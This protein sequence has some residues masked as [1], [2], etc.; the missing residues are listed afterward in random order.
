MIY[1]PGH[2]QHFTRRNDNKGLTTEQLRQKY[3][4]EQLLFEQF[5][6][7]TSISTAAG[8]GGGRRSA[9]YI[10]T[11]SDAQAFIAAVNLTDPLQTQAVDQLVINLKSYGIWSK[12]QVIY[13]FVGGTSITHK[14]N[15]KDPRDLDAAYRLTFSG[16]WVHSSTGITGNGS[17][18]YALVPIAVDSTTVGVYYR[19]AF[20]GTA[21]GYVRYTDSSDPEQP[22]SIENGYKLGENYVNGDSQSLPISNGTGGGLLSL[23]FDSGFPSYSYSTIKNNTIIT[24]PYSFTTLSTTLTTLGAQNVDSFDQYGTF[25]G[26]SKQDYSA[27]NIAF[28]YFSNT[29]LTDTEVYTLYAAVDAFQ[30]TLGRQV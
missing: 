18:A 2:W 23:R 5:I 29:I 6:A 14:W 24:A 21:L 25:I 1:H 17:N 22:Q 7:T 28:S 12:L 27:A 9:S 15:L 26:N 19:N 4:K 20:S 8:S 13:P 11:D 10:V 16:G 3:V 30:T